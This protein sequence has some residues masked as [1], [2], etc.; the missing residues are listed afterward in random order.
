M[1]GGEEGYDNVL[2]K[3]QI[4][5]IN[6]Q[7]IYFMAKQGFSHRLSNQLLE[8]RLTVIT[9]KSSVQVHSSVQIL[10]KVTMI[11]Y[12]FW[13]QNLKPRENNWKY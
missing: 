12:C 9:G 8:E 13:K 6:V 5:D 7:V 3:R 10:E 2:A 1:S 11:T 4:N